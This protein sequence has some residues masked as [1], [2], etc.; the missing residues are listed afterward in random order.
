TCLCESA[1]FSLFGGLWFLR[2]RR[3][4]RQLAAHLFCVIQH[5]RVSRIVDPFLFRSSIEFWMQIVAALLSIL[6]L[7]DGDAVCVCPL[8][9]ADAGDLPGALHSGVT[10]ADLELIVGKLLRNVH[11]GESPDAG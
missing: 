5:V 4:N 9:L 1:A 8:I 7:F 6:F 10:T 3:D 2:V 11:R